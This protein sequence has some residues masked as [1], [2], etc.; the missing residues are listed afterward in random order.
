MFNNVNAYNYGLSENNSIVD[1]YFFPE[2]SVISSQRNLIN[3]DKAKPI[4]C[5][6]RRLDDFVLESNLK[7]ID[8]IKCDVEGGELLV[9]NGTQNSICR[10]LPIIFIEL[11]H[12]WNLQ[13][14]Y[15]PNQ[16][17]DM[18]AK[19]GYNCYYPHNEHLESIQ[20]LDKE[21]QDERLNYLFLHKEKHEKFIK[22]FKIL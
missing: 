1:F 12:R 7:K 13:F 5:E 14:G 4:K 6:V 22:T 18:L 2:G 11:F 20:N 15:H 3:C 21:P 19:V 8:F 9:L 16:V 17:I 10:F